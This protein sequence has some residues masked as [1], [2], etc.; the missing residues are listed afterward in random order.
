MHL[1]LGFQQLTGASVE[2]L[3]TT[4]DHVFD[5]PADDDR[6]IW[7]LGH[8][9]IGHLDL[10]QQVSDVPKRAGLICLK[11]RNDDFTEDIGELGVA[12]MTNEIRE[13]NGMAVAHVVRPGL[14]IR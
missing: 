6:H 12:D 3:F 5:Q 11:S 14:L 10:V 8:G 4:H 9:E 13:V 1:L 7:P 2:L